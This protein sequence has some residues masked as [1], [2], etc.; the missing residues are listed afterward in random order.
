MLAEMRFINGRTN[1][2]MNIHVLATGPIT[3]PILDDIAAIIIAWFTTD[4][5][6]SASI[7]WLANEVVMTGLNSLADPRKSYPIE[8]PIGGSDASAELPANVTV[9]IKEDVGHRGRGLAGRVFWV[10]LASGSTVGDLLTNA[11]GVA[12]IM[13]MDNLKANIALVPGVEGI[14]V[15]HLVVGGV[16]PPTATSDLVTT[17]LLTDNTLDSQ[18]DRLPGHKKHKR[19]PVA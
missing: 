15:P 4:W 7:G 16:R 13:A 10:G 6:P 2:S 8:P 11:A 1:A 9:A 5:A 18:R 19:P 12:L 3:I 14:C 17:F